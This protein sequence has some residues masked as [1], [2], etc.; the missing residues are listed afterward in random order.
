MRSNIGI[1]GCAMGMVSLECR[2]L[3]LEVFQV[4]EHHGRYRMPGQPRPQIGDFFLQLG[5]PF[6]VSH[7]AVLSSAE[8]GHQ[9][10]W[11]LQ[12]VQRGQ[13]VGCHKVSGQKGIDGQSLRTDHGNTNCCLA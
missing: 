10:R 7:V 1:S 4:D 9:A 5:D 13:D 3:I 11:I 12:Q 2:Q 6:L 8:S